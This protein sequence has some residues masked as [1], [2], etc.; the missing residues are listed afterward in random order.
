MKVLITGVAGFIGSHTAEKFLEEGHSVVGVDDLSTGSNHNVPDGVDFKFLDIT[1]GDA[2]IGLFDKEKPEAVVHLAAQPSLLESKMYPAFDAS[3]N[4]IGTINTL[5]ASKSI[6][7]KKFVFASTSAVY[8]GEAVEDS[9]ALFPI[10][11]YGI[12][13]LSAERYV[14]ALLECSVVLRYGNVYG[15]RQVPLGEN[16]LVPRVLEHIYKKAEFVVNGDGLQTRDFIYVKDIANANYV[17]TI[18]DLPNDV[19][20]NISSG[21]SYTVADV[22]KEIARLTAFTGQLEHGPKKENERIDVKMPNELMMQSFDWE[23]QFTLHRGL[24]ETV[25]EYDKG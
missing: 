19:A 18:Q 7:V 4:I 23:P 24:K 9:L 6:G 25:L 22:V 8:S 5:M 11:P 3:V 10:N 12:S 13:K 21:V 20:F 14:S 16:Q 2:L 15:P 1:E 17:A